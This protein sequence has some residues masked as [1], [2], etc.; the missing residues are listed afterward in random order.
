M[1]VVGQVVQFF[2][3]KG[4]PD[5]QIAG[6]LGNMQ[7]ESGFDT[8]A[9]NSGEGAVG[10]VQWEGGRDD[11]M[12]NWA[13]QHNLVPADLQAQLGFIW[14][15]L[16]TSESGA[17]HAF[18]QTTNAADAAAVWD[19]Q[20]ERSSGDARQ[21]RINS[22][23]AF[24]SSGLTSGGGGGGGAGARTGGGGSVATPK[25]SK[26]RRSDYLGG[27][28]TELRTLVNKIP[29]LRGLLSQAVQGQWS[30]DKFVQEIQTSQW[31]KN[32]SDTVR[33]ALATKFAD[34]ATWDQNLN[35]EKGTLHALAQQLGFELTPDQLDAIATNAMLTGNTNNTAWLTHAINKRQDFSTVK[36][37]SDLNGQMAQAYGQLQD[38][39][40]SYGLSPS[41]AALAQSARSVVAGNNSLDA[42]K[43]NYISQ[44]SSR[45]PGLADQLHAGMTVTEIADPYIQ[46]YS[47]LLEVDPN[48]VG[49]DNTTI[50]KALQGVPTGKSSIPSVMTLTDF[51]DQVRKDP[52][53][54]FTNNAHEA[55]GTALAQIG[56][57]F[58][59][60]F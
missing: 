23:N 46:T 10:L 13:F 57:D 21:D 48:A 41:P 8:G 16:N 24:F 35:N 6:I 3:S 19:A 25:A 30:R 12:R 7:I 32:H 52:R 47:Q 2:R 54:Q 43:Q 22:A 28:G 58:G 18:R 4:L 53:W 15:E 26:L 42:Y 44:A 40:K 51:E 36:S 59:F 60:G 27:Q 33:Q 1:S 38:L 56:A 14:H 50:R 11:A 39:A 9:V 31:W 17:F 20:Y 55:V 34:P 37:G 45:Y 49:I 29:A 5:Y